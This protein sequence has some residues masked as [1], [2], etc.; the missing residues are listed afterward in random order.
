LIS[1]NFFATEK[2]IRHKIEAEYAAGDPTFARMVGDL[3][4][5]PLLPRNRVTMFQDGHEIFPAMLEGIRSS[6]RTITFENFVFHEG[7]VS[8]AFAEAMAERARAGVK[9]H[10][11]QDALGCNCLRGRAIR[12]MR[13]AGVEVEIFRFFK[14]TGMNFR[15]HRKLLT[16]DGRVA[17]IGGVG[18][19]DDWDGNG[20]TP[21]PLARHTVSRG[22][23][24]RGAGATGVSR[25]L[26]GNTRCG[27]ARRR[28]FPGTRAHRQ[29]ALSGFQKLC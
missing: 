25:Q 11:L 19:S 5:P 21:R 16:I 24:D 20:T 18:I 10:F 4:G 7:R 22:R 14:L 2:K 26:D 29:C 27:P 13:R 6:Q 3:L 28:L 12:L 15:T 1:R 23:T 8:D 9:V 17:F